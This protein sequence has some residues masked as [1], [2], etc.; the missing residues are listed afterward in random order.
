LTLQTPLDVAQNIPQARRAKE[1]GSLDVSRTFS[2]TEFGARLYAAG[3]RRDD[4]STNTK[5]LPG[6]STWNFFASRRIS[7]DWIA[8]VKVENAFDK[9]YQLA[10]GYNTPGRG[11]Y[12]TLQYQPK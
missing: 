12:A 1:F 7:S 3:A 5:M 9:Q 2:G 8:R 10:Y 6:Y 11:I 4:N